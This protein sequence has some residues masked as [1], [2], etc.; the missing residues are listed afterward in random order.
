[1]LQTYCQDLCLNVQTTFRKALLEIASKSKMTFSTLRRSAAESQIDEL[2]RDNCI[3]LNNLEA[4]RQRLHD[5]YT[6]MDVDAIMVVLERDRAAKEAA[7]AEG[8][9]PAPPPTD[10]LTGSIKVRASPAGGRA[11]SGHR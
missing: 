6:M 11:R 5:L 9:L 4:V 3:K 8:R 1:V 7:I 2:M 10:S